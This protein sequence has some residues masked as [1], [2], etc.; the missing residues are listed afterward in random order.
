MLTAYKSPVRNFTTQPEFDLYQGRG[1]FLTIDNTYTSK[2]QKEQKGK[3]I[4]VPFN[5]F[6]IRVHTCS[7]YNK[8][9]VPIRNKLPIQATF[10]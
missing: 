5:V 2:K 4:C 1:E 8:Q 7:E 10:P 3:K 6:M 9:T